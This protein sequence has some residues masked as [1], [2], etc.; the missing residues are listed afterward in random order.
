VQ[1]AVGRGPTVDVLPNCRS[2]WYVTYAAGQTCGPFTEADVRG[3]IAWQQI[4]ITDWVIAEGGTPW[5]LITQSPF[6]PFIV[7]QA[8]IDQ[9]ATS[10]CPRCGAAMVV[11]LQRSSASKALIYGGYFHC[12]VDCFRSSSALSLDETHNLDMNVHAANIGRLRVPPAGSLKESTRIAWAAPWRTPGD[13]LYVKTNSD[14]GG[15][16]YLNLAVELELLR[17]V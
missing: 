11:V 4:K 7:T 5:V 17:C 16:V 12:L 15:L 10:T 13:R 8:S 2:V 6:A 14:S 9:L 3:M 1:S